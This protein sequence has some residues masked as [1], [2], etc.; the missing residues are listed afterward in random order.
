M[1]REEHSI[2][3]MRTDRESEAIS[4][5]ANAT[6]RSDVVKNA[7]T[8][9]YVNGDGKGLDLSRK[10]SMTERFRATLRRT[11]VKEIK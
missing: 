6:R 5:L 9:T 10:A 11:T 7:S 8:T 4:L 2:S 1:R 3:H